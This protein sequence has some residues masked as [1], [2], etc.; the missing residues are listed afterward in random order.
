MNFK[1][2]GNYKIW[3]GISALVMAVGLVMAMMSGV[4]LGIDFTGGTMMQFDMGRDFSVEEVKAVIEPFAL[5]ADIL[6][7]GAEKHEVII[8]TKINLSNDRRIEIFNSLKE[9]FNLEDSAFRQTQQFGPSVGSEIQNKALISIILASIGMLVY[10]TFR[11]ELKFG[12][13]AILALIHDVLIVLSIYAIFRVPVNSSF[14]AAILTI[15]GYSINDTI[16]VFDRLRENIKY[17][18]KKSHFEIADL[19]IKQTLRRSLN[20]SLTTLL[21]IGSLYVLGVESI[22]EFAL[23]LLAGILTGTY[24][25]IFIA[26]PIWALWKN[27]E[28]KRHSYK[29]A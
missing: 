14:I 24:S 6:H 25:S 4:N 3:F 28:S 19:S 16:V 8:K 18:N 27:H 15:V 5:E 2:C 17:M 12:I 13:A 22:K 11:F 29:A 9:A 7:A 20:T 1:I 10:V 26:S 23:P 21:V